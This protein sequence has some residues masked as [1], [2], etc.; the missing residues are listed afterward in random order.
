[1]KINIRSFLFFKFLSY[2]N[3]QILC[4]KENMNYCDFLYQVIILKVIPSLQGPQW[5]AILQL[6]QSP[7]WIWPQQTEALGA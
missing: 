2:I 5:I 1:M 4:K 6:L 7:K 3:L